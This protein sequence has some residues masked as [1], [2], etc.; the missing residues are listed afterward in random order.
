M[1]YIPTSVRAHEYFSI[2]LHLN[3]NLSTSDVIYALTGKEKGARHRHHV[4][5]KQD[6]PFRIRHTRS[7]ALWVFSNYKTTRDCEFNFRLDTGLG[8]N[9]YRKRPGS[10]GGAVD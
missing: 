5:Q 8:S 2:N 6:V 1:L 4:M 9:L 7:H 3:W 10:V